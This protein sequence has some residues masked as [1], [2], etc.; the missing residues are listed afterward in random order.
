MIAVGG[1]HSH[2]VPMALIRQ[3]VRL[4][5]KDLTL[6]GSI[7]V[8]LPIDLLVSNKCVKRV[9]APY[10]GFEMWG[11]APSFR[12]AVETHQIE[13]PDVCEAFPVYSLRAGSDGVPFHPFPEGIHQYSDIHKQSD[14]Y[15]QVTDPFTQKQLYAVKAITPDV[16]IIHAQAATRNGD[17][18]HRGSVVIDHLMA[19]SAK[20][21]IATVEEIVDEYDPNEITVPS[22]N[23][24]YII[25]LPHSAYPTSSHG[26]YRYDASEIKN[27]LEITQADERIKQYLN[28]I[29][30]ST[31]EDYL[32]SHFKETPLPEV[33]SL[34]QTYTISE[35]VA[36]L[37]ARDI[38]DYE[39]GICGAVSDIPMAAMQ[40]AERL[41]APN[42]RWIA[43]GSG[44]INPRGALVPSS[45]DYQMSVSS[46][47]RLS[48]NEV[49]P[50]E[51]EKLD[52]FFAGGLQIDGV[53]NTNLAGIPSEDGWKLRGPGSVGL[54]FLPRAKRVYLYTL[55]HNSRSLVK[56]VSY[57]SGPGHQQPENPFG[58]GPSLLITSKCVFRWNVE[59]FSWELVSLHPGIE[60][61]DVKES[62]GFDFLISEPVPI[63]KIPT[64][65]E[66]ALLREID[67][68]GYLRGVS[69]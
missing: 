67:K 40:L 6:I 7:S 8:G 5:I 41:H 33:S 46:N 9:L 14:L 21:V 20:L 51:M 65:K 54:A 53:G 37:F 62:T 58:G 4:G 28:E 10:V 24:D 3:I 1:V 56:K 26:I 19:S 38:K 18:I 45:T 13:A 2:N 32:T 42:L 61:S 59:K 30:E 44:Y 22:I 47:A 17:L 57:I 12:K 23:V 31:E 25:H 36:V 55:V 60:L 48:M 49:I 27:Y 11:L 50:V 63:T 16:A 52:F 39:L 34:G 68:Y 35:L 15:K 43:G 64:E 69:D 66:L 29:N